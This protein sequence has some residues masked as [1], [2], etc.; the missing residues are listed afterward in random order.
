MRCGAGASTIGPMKPIKQLLALVC[1]CTAI[2]STPAAAPAA[3][4]GWLDGNISYTYT[5]NC[6]SIIWGAPYIEALSGHMAGFYVNDPWQ[7]V[8]E[9][10][11]IRTIITTLGAPCAGPY[12]VPEFALHQDMELAISP[13]YPVLCYVQFP[14][15]NQFKKVGASECPQQPQPGRFSRSVRFAP[16]GQGAWALPQGA[17]VQV[18]IPVYVRKQFKGMAG[19]G[20]KENCGGCF[21]A[22]SQMLSGGTDPS[23]LAKQ[24][25]TTD[26]TYPATAFPA[27]GPRMI[28]GP[29][30][31]R[32]HAYLYNY[33]APGQASI[34]ICEAAHY[35][36]DA[37]KQCTGGWRDTAPATV[38]ADTYAMQL[39]AS[40]D[41]VK[42]NTAYKAM[43]FFDFQ[44]P[45][46][47]NV[48]KPGTSHV[49]SFTS[50]P[51]GVPNPAPVSGESSN[52]GAPPANAPQPPTA[53]PVVDNGTTTVT[54]DDVRNGAEPNKPLPG[55]L[56]QPQPNPPGDTPKPP[57]P[58]RLA[59]VA[60][61]TGV[62]RAALLKAGIKVPV[63]CRRAC[64][65]SLELRVDAKTDKRYKLTS[66]VVGKAAKTFAAAG[67]AGVKVKLG[68]VA[69]KRLKRAKRL[70]LTLRSTATEAGAEPLI[71]DQLVAV[72]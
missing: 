54:P 68:A 49:V 52:A 5:T 22:P 17:W 65:V 48:V 23:G 47:G 37:T 70:T 66:R 21:H 7:G 4:S 10:F 43:V 56:P 2:A 9:V 20:D 38:H 27:G 13:Q 67:K 35:Q 28:T 63:E 50:G 62:K 25:V 45:E 64:R 69:R 24:W 46:E 71:A 42:P 53:P 41:D 26:K 29:N 1:A 34:A 11:Y 19:P 14:N 39:E 60:A 30:H 55:G 57:V 61:P 6:A 44:Q 72:K 3:Q 59:T 31:V 36:G 51:E 8:G 16:P 40:F 32:L 15:E 18:Q 33:F 58:D 12:A